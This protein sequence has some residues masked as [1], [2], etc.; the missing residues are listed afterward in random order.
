V[1]ALVLHYK[2]ADIATQKC[3]CCF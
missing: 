2:T 1:K 3:S